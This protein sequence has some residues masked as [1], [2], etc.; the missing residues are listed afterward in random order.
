MARRFITARFANT[1]EKTSGDPLFSS[2]PPFSFV[3]D[4]KPS[5]DFLDKWKT[6]RQRRKLDEHRTAHTVIYADPAGKLLILCEAVEYD[7]F[8][9]VEWTLYFKNFG[10]SDTP[11]LENIQSLDV[12]WQGDEKGEFLLHH[13]VGSP[14]KDTDYSP[15][16]TPLPVGASKRIAAKE[17][18]STQSDL[19]YFNLERRKDEGLI[20]VVGW[21]GQWAADFTRDADRGIHLRAGQELTHFK[22]H[23]NEEIRTPLSVLQFWKGGDW[24]RAQNIWR[25]WMFAYNIPRPGGKLPQPQLLASDCLCGSALLTGAT[26]ANQ[27]ALVDRYLEERIKLDYLWMDAGWFVQNDGWPQVGTWE[28]EPNRF[29]R[30]LKPISDHAHSHGLKFLLWFEP[31]R[32]ATGTW[33][34]ENHPEW[35]LGGT[36]GEIFKE[37]NPNELPGGVFNLGDPEARKWM[38]ERIDKLIVEQGVDLY[39]QDFNIDPLPFW[40]YA[41]PEDRQGITEIRHVTGLLAFW[42][43]LQRRHPE[44]PFDEC[45]SGG[46]RNDLEMMRRAV[47]LWRS[48]RLYVPIGQQCLTYGI[49]LWIPYYGTNTIG[50]SRPTSLNSGKTPFEPYAFWSTAA[51]STLFTFDVREKELDY[52]LIRKLVSQWREINFCYAGDFYPLTKTGL[53]NDTWIAWQYDCPEKSSGVVQAFRRP[54]CGYVGIRLKLRGLEP[55]AKYRITRLDRTGEAEFSGEELMQKGLSVSIDEAPGAA[56]IVYRRVP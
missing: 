31:E 19:S 9:T 54:E 24:I 8:P 14:T 35:I 26:E 40:R 33:L 7:D 3:Y 22:L 21:P 27:I 11:I 48:D 49:S 34:A 50:C 38:T 15:L 28:V 42:D 18:R 51:P 2:G 30:G 20:A 25:R 39:R 4:G 5:A 12:R 46:R 29:P 1:Q 52:D 10:E 44:M 45:A 47:P 23:P 41:E 43:E 32:V 13:N 56:V 17:G 36:K 37:G 55:Q 6:Q 53:E 16:E